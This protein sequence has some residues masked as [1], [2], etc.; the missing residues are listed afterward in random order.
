VTINDL[1]N[2]N[3]VVV[4]QAAVLFAPANTPLPALS[5]ISF[6]DPFNLDPW[7]TYVLNGTVGATSFTLTYKGSV[8]GSLTVTGLTAAAIQAALAALP[9]IGAGNVTVTGTAATGWRVSIAE[10]VSGGALTITGTGGGTPTVTAALWAPC[11]A[12]DAGWTFATNK[13]TN[14]T[15]IE[16]QSTPAGQTITSQKVTIEGALAED[17]SRTLALAYNAY[18]TTTAQAT[19]IPGTEELNP[20]DDVL[21]YAVAMIMKQWNGNPR[22]VYAPAWTQLNNVSTAMR[23]ASAKRMYPVAFGTICAT[24][25]IRIINFVSPGL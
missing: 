18:L 21:S 12:T 3:A 2:T 10:R 22:L 8:T 4:G 9:T 16:E 14:D 23:R 11:G 5:T 24:T 13:S 6:T 15:T 7:L 25:A 20:T 1:Y 19:G 17:I